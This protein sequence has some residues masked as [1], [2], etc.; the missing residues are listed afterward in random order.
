MDY[1]N[2][3]GDNDLRRPVNLIG[4]AWDD[5]NYFAHE[6]HVSEQMGDLPRRI[7]MSVLLPAIVIALES[8]WLYNQDKQ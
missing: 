8:N 6:G 3:C 4:D 5:F 7:G 2:S 1:S